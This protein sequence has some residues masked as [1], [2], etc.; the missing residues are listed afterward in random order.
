MVSGGSRSRGL[1]W[2]YAMLLFMVLECL[3][4]AEVEFFDRP[5]HTGVG[6]LEIYFFVVLATMLG[7]VVGI[8]LVLRSQYRL[9]GLVQIVS[10]AIH[11][12]KG[13]GFVGVIGGMRARAYASEAAERP[14]W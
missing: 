10:S 8:V 11:V 13:E 6:A 3:V 1:G 12:L 4:V 5:A 2:A 14:S 9:G 7:Q